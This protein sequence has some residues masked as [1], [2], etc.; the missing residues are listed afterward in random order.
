[1]AARTHNARTSPGAAS[2]E[3][4]TLSER[5]AEFFLLNFCAWSVR[6]FSESARLRSTI[7]SERALRPAAR[8]YVLRCRG[9]V[10]RCAFSP[11]AERLPVRAPRRLVCMIVRGVDA[12]RVPD[13]GR[14]T[15]AGSI[16][17]ECATVRSVAADLHYC[18]LASAARE[19]APRGRR[20]SRP[21]ASEH[22]DPPHRWTCRSRTAAILGLAS[23]RRPAVPHAEDTELRIGM[24]PRRS[25]EPRRRRHVPQP[26][27]RRQS[28]QGRA[29]PFDTGQPSSSSPHAQRAHGDL[30]SAL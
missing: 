27:A 15:P 3:P 19:P 6:E 2:F 14:A 5:L 7:A 1:M 20:P 30:L 29:A 17:R 13:Y 18:D 25:G 28:R 24:A 8:E 21:R 23:P 22:G 4:R 16:L 10:R 11:R 12:A 9:L 26:W